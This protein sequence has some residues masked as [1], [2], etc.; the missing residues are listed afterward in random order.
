METLLDPPAGPVAAVAGARETVA[1]LGETLWSTARAEDLL[2]VTEELQRLRS[3]VA[4]VEAQVAVEVEASQAAK[5]AGWVSPGDYL[6]HVAGGRHGHGSRTLRTARPLCGERGATW[7]ALQ[8]GDVSPEQAEV[9][10][11]VIDR[12]P[13][14]PGLRAEAER[15]LL[16]QAAS[17]NA[18]E[19][20]KAGDHLLEVL[21]PDGTARVEEAA[22]DRLERSAHL[23]RFLAISED[24]I[25]GVRLRG[26]GTVEDATLIKTALYALA[27]PRP[28]ADPDCGETARDLRDH[29]AR[30]WD[31]LVETCVKASE[32]EGLLPEQHGAKP[33]LTVTLTLEQLREGLGVATLDTGDQVSAT[34]LRRL[35]CD[36]EVIPAVLASLGEVLDVGRSQRL[37]TTAIWKA[38]T[39]RDQH[40]RFPGCRRLPLACD[41]HHLTHWADGGSTS[42]D[43]LVLLCRAHH[44]L[45][46]ATPWEVRLNPLDRQPEFRRPPRRDQDPPSDHWIRAMPAGAGQ[47]QRRTRPT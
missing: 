46:H 32:V 25:G 29:G 11:A 37:V 4:A 2:A 8:A 23:G 6:T 27:A 30:T 22:L 33:R 40:C 39:L 45:I 38:L 43:N 16:D 19:L 20:R 17:L 15:L 31:A 1:A 44:T 5:T 7:V 21:D 42:L 36:A 28:G 9:V 41:A 24:G 13:V 14:Q 18:S 12:L 34:A 47:S 3:A 35:A 10:V 26:R